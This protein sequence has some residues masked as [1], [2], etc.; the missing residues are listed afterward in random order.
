M[1]RKVVINLFGGPGASKST[2]S[3]GVFSL[4]KLQGVNC[5]LVTEFAKALTWRDSKN[6]IKDQ[7]YILGNQYHNMFILKDKVDVI[8]TDS[9]LLLNLLYEDVSEL[10]TK[11]ALELFNRF[12]NL[13]YYINRKKEYNDIGRRQTENEAI[14]ID[15]KC[16]KMLYTNEIDYE[17][18]DGDYECINKIVDDVLN[19]QNK[20]NNL[21][22]FQINTTN[23]ND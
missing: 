1:D 3:A 16:K 9:P 21:K 6:C 2:T 11:F 14:T 5:E 22:D 15:Y 8:I 12:D 19:I 23:I 4:L 20:Q 7:V 17:Q 10:H 18:V 13:N